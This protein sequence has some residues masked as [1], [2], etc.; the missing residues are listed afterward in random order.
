MLEEILNSDESFAIIVEIG[1]KEAD[2]VY[3]GNECFVD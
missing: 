2:F 3:Y 1:I